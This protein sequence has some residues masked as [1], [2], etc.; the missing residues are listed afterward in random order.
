MTDTLYKYDTKG[1]LRTWRMEIDGSRYRTAAGVAGGVEVFS[2]WTQAKAKNIGKANET[3]PED[4]AKLEVA[5]KYEHKLTREY[6]KS[7][8]A[9]QSGAHFFKPMLAKEYSGFPLWQTVYAQPKLDGMRCIATRQ[10]LFSRQ[11][12]AILGCPHI[13]EALKPAFETD[14][15]LIL[16]G[17]LYNHE[18]KDDFPKLMSLC[19]KQDPSE[20]ELAES[21]RLVQYHVYDCPSKADRRFSI[22]IAYANQSLQYLS[23]ESCIWKVETVAFEGKPEDSERFNT[24]HGACVAAGY[25][26]SMLRLDTPYEQKRSKNLLKR[27]DFLEDEFPVL[28][29]EEGIG[30]WSGKVKSVVCKAKNGKEFGAGLKGTMEYAESLIGKSFQTAT[31]RY[32]EL[33]PDGVPR[34]GIVIALYDGERDV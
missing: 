14:P 26:G 10:G 4:Q 22:R 30:N 9:A 33:T 11:G 27:K 3:S 24:F 18:L 2:E 6:H 8:E 31:V 20:E 32:F 7:T 13:Y 29:L 25:E 17:E 23:E 16:D 12:K 5:S 34:F 1:G 21:G 28:S 19:K 15:N